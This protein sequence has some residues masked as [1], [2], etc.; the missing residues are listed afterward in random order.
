MAKAEAAV[1]SVEA[2][3]AFLHASKEPDAPGI[4]GS[5]GMAIGHKRPRPL[6]ECRGLHMNKAVPKSYFDKLG[7]VSLMNQHHRLQHTS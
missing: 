3:E 2:V 6:V 7:L 4:I 1:Y 5:H